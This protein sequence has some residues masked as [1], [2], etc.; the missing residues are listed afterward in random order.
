MRFITLFLSAIFL[1]TP[2]IL[3]VFFIMP[4]GN[5]QELDAAAWAYFFYNYIWIFRILGGGL[6]LY[7]AK[8]YWVESKGK[9][10]PKATIV[11][12]LMVYLSIA[13]MTT[14]VMRA[15]K[16]FYQP[17]HKILANAADNQIKSQKL[18]MGI[19]YKN[20]ARAYPVQ[21]LGYHHQVVDTIGGEPV[22]IT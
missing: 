16:M 19:F 22:I 21:F 20:E 18:E 13:Y 1:T 11:V 15:D 8:A 2:E 14:F 12:L 10:I 7:L 6:F 4:I 9:M 3:S 5:S 17:K